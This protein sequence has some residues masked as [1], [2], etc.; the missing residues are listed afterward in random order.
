MAKQAGQAA[1]TVGFPLGC[2]QPQ[3]DF[4]WDASGLWLAPDVDRALLCVFPSVSCC[5]CPAVEM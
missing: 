4:P 3:Q 2:Q 1:A 5:V